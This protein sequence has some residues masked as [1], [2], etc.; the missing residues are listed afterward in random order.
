MSD[1]ADIVHLVSTEKF[2]KWLQENRRVSSMSERDLLR[3]ARLSHSTL[4]NMRRARDVKLSTVAM[5]ADVFGY[6]VALIKRD[7]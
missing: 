7:K 3:A 2:L 5:A 6:D 4:S 1:G